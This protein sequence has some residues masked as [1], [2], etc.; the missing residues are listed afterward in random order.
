MK[1]IITIA[2][3]AFTVILSVGRAGAQ[4]PAIR[5]NV[6]FNFTAGDKLLPPGLYTITLA[7]AGIIEI[8]NR[9]QHISIGST[10]LPDNRE[11]EHGG[12]LV[13]ARYGNQYFLHEVLCDFAS[14]NVYLP[15]TKSEK[16]VRMQEAMVENANQVLVAM[17]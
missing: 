8:R 17:K 12:E 5:V 16:R 9:G 15:T 4:V 7:S 2:I 11:S 6:P 14:M 1:R 10:A 13:F 3:F